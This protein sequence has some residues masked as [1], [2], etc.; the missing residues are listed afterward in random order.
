MKLV[1]SFLISIFVQILTQVSYCIDSAYKTFNFFMLKQ[2]HL[3][4]NCGFLY[5][6]YHLLIFWLW[7]LGL[8]LGYSCSLHTKLSWWTWSVETFLI[9]IAHCKSFT[10]GQS[11][12][13]KL[14]NGQSWQIRK[15]G[16]RSDNQTSGTLWKMAVAV[17]LPQCL[18]WHYVRMGGLGEA[19]S[20]LTEGSSTTLAVSWSMWQ[21]NN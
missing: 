19:Q 3:G 18:L 14:E 8:T 6:T 17:D 5:L 10:S 4:K 20:F 13:L 16:K 1:H 12:D 7:P 11:W 21:L 2:I 9:C 15:W